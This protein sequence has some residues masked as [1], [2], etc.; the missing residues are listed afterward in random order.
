MKMLHND[1]GEFIKILE[2]TSAQTGFPLRLLEKDYYITVVLSKI[3]KLSGDLIFKGGTCLSKIYYS[4]YRLSE[5]MDFTLKLPGNA[6]RTIR[7]NA[8]RPIKELMKS[9]LKEFGMSIEGLERAG[10]RESTQYI[11]F[12][13]YNSVVL[14]KKESIKLEIGLRFNPV[15]SSV[16][17]KVN[18]KFLHPFTKEPLFDAGSVSCLAAKELVAEKLRA[19]A[20]RETIAARDFYDLG[21]LLKEKFDFKDKVFLS[22]FKKK[23]EEDNFS[24]D[25][26]KYKVNLGRTDKEIDEMKSRVGDELLSVLTTDEQKSFDMQK[27]LDKLNNAFGNK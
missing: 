13:D 26:A 17:K 10:H 11:F 20:T 19:A 1:K 16:T 22:L 25:L 24:P 5:D 8:M 18:H 7:S 12:L 9:F 21:Y 14:S 2:R 15:L 27:I 6:T 4:Y 3:N 23:L